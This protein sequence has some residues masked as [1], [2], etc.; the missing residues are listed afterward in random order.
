LQ[1][2]GAS[3]TYTSS[4]QLTGGQV[5][6]GQTERTTISG[7]GSIRG[8]RAGLLLTLTGAKKQSFDVVIDD[9]D[10]YVKPHGMQR[11][12]FYDPAVVAE[13]FI[14]GIR[15]NLLRDIVLLAAAE[16]SAGSLRFKDGGL[17]HAYTIRPGRDQLEQLLSTVGFQS[18]ADEAQFVKSSSA[19]ITLYTG[20]S[21]GRLDR[22]E[23]SLTAPFDNRG[24]KLTLAPAVV[25][26]NFGH[27]GQV[28]V[29]ADWVAVQ[30]QDLFS[31]AQ[32]SSSG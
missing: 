9:A 30:P 3:F 29:P 22:V 18:S 5:P 23:M 14:E 6:S 4:F 13:P 27:G 11:P 24:T 10:V 21:D 2:K 28:T 12:Y 31:T 25:F 15:L 1:S 19:S 17:Q 32:V 26:K 7:S 20:Y 8:D 16:P